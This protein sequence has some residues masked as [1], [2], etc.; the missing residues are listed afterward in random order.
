MFSNGQVSF[1]CVADLRG[2]WERQKSSLGLL[3][4]SLY[5]AARIANFERI[6]GFSVPSIILADLLGNKCLFERVQKVMF[7]DL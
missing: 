1:L 5:R 2:L 3:P 4:N 6:L 7:C